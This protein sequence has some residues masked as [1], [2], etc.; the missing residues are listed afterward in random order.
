M[1]TDVDRFLTS[2]AACAGSAGVS[3]AAIA[4]LRSRLASGSGSGIYLLGLQCA[5][6]ALA[7]SNQPREAE[8]LV[9]ACAPHVRTELVT[10]FRVLACMNELLA[11]GA[12]EASMALFS[13]LS[14]VGAVSGSSDGL[15]TALARAAAYAPSRKSIALAITTVG[16][17]HEAVRGPSVTA[18][19][20]LVSLCLETV[21]REAVEVTRQEIE[22]RL[23]EPAG[24]ALGVPSNNDEDDDDDDV[25]PLHRAFAL[26]DGY[27]DAAGRSSMG[28]NRAFVLGAL[29]DP[30]TGAALARPL[31]H[32]ALEAMRRC[33]V[34]SLGA[35]NSWGAGSSAA[36]ELAATSHHR[37]PDDDVLSGVDVGLFDGLYAWHTNFLM[38]EGG[39][40]ECAAELEL[41]RR[42]SVSRAVEIPTKF[43][44]SL[45]CVMAI[46]AAM[47]AAGWPRHHLEPLY[48]FLLA[49]HK[50]SLITEADVDELFGVDELLPARQA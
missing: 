40:D 3:V 1:H 2:L 8:A 4:K 17:M 29:V 22:Q 36:T 15:L 21:S 30:H 7:R 5:A 48:T 47:T 42:R 41:E 31:V 27:C 33:A 35:S 45:E 26:Y 23:L 38:L 39:G 9:V 20:L 34:L 18:Y 14:R 37:R 43:A 6:A 10:P 11:A 13:A 28:L 19:A 46:A 12:P 16:Q 25:D 24:T 44:G 32:V 50:P 49:T